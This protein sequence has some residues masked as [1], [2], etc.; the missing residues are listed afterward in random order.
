MSIK[1][2][3]PDNEYQAALAANNPTA[4]NPFATIADTGG[5]GG[6]VNSVTGLNTDNTD[7]ANPIIKIAV[8]NSTITG[9]GTVAD[10]LVSVGGGVGSTARNLSS[11]QW[12]KTIPLPIVFPDEGFSNGFTF[13][14]I[15]DIVLGGTTTYN[16]FSISYGIEIELSGSGS[17]LI[18]LNGTNYS[19][20]F[21]T[22]LDTT[23]LNFVTVNEANLNAD[24]IRVFNLNA[25]NN[26]PFGVKNARLR[27]CASDTILNAMTI[28]NVL[29]NL[30]GVISNPFVPLSTV[31]YPDHVIVPYE[32]EPYN[33]QRLHHN[34][35]VNFGLNSSNVQTVALSLRRYEND[36]IIGSEIPIVA[37]PDV[38]S[39]QNSFISYTANI[40][41]P[42]VQGGFYFALRN[43]SGASLDIQNGM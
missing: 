15:N 5:G 30:N 2:N 39:Q 42:F 14:D 3:L 38:Q 34:F 28:N 8:D 41:D 17:A 1:R 6:S 4:A 24:N 36:S 20:L 23:A 32:N 21:N 12:S 22:D 37:N 10:P 26:S 18:N 40:N 25:D 35:R 11:T 31:S 7:S 33:G 43:G 19:L 16:Q 29:G 9:T 13:F 27:F